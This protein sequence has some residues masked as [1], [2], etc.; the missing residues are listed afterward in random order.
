M[1]ALHAAAH[2]LHPRSCLRV[3]AWATFR[4]TKHPAAHV[5][6]KWWWRHVLAI[7]MWQRKTQRLQCHALH[8]A[9][10][11][12]LLGCSAKQHTHLGALSSQSADHASIT[13][14]TCCKQ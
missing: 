1:L 3:L 6:L 7:N 13:M 8:A 12:C 14:R 2:Q 11:L 10:K 9:I 4:Y 5:A